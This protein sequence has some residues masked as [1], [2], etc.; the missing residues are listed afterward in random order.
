MEQSSSVI[1]CTKNR[2]DDVVR[3]IDSLSEQLDAPQELIIVDSSDVPLEKNQRFATRFNP[4]CFPKTTLKYIHTTPGLTRQRNIGIEHSSSSIIYFFDDDVVLEKEYLLRM[5]EAFQSHP[6]CAGGM[7]TQTNISLLSW[8]YRL[9]RSFFL[10]QRTYASG[11]F[12]ASGM[13]TH[14]YGTDQF[15]YVQALGGCCMA[16]RKEAL[17]VHRFDESF[18]GYAFMEDCDISYRISVSQP[19]FF[20]PSAR[21]AHHESPVARDKLFDSSAMFT[22]NYSYLFFKDHYPK[23]RFKIVAYY[24][25]LFGLFLECIFLRDWIRLRGYYSG[26]QRFKKG[27]K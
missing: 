4:Q 22:F 13:P 8:K 7:G 26:L 1:I 15:K 11:N 14:P 27:K 10:L 25:S 12:T 5:N 9:F 17:A 21:L 6:S 23:N 24:W 16:F 19:L 20:N 2:I 3:C 18:G